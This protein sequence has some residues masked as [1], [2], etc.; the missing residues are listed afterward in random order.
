[1]RIKNLALLEEVTLEFESG[2]TAVTGETGAGKSV[3]LGA[4]GLLSGARTDKGV[5]RQ[6]QD[7]LEVEAALYFADALPIDKL[8]EAAG[9]P[10]CEDGLLLL[11]R[12][13]HQRKIPR[14]QINGSL[15]TLSQLQALGESWIDFHGPGE[16]QKLFQEKR[17]LEM[18]DTYAGNVK[19]LAA[20]ALSFEEWRKALREIETL[21]TGERLD[22]DELD[23]VRKQIKK[24]D[25]VDVSEDTIEELE[26]D[27][28]RISSAQELVSLA[29]ACSEGMIGEQSVNDLLGGVLLRLEEM[30][31]LDEGSQTLLERAQ[32]L[33]IEL[34]DLGQEL[35]HLVNDYDFDPEAIEAVTEHMNLWQELRRKYGGSVEAVLSKREELAQKIEIQ[36]DLEGVLAKKRKASVDLEAELKKQ[37]QKLTASRRKSAKLLSQKAADLLQALGFKKARLEIELIADAKLHNYGDSHCQFLFAPNAGQKLQPLNKIASSGETARVM[38][39]LKTVL[40]EADATP[41]L[42]FDE[43]DANVGGEVGRAVGAE[44]VRLAKKHQVLCVTHLPQVAS[45]AHNHYVVTKS[46]DKDSTAVD[47]ASL[48]DSR[49]DRLEELARMLG[50]RKSASARAHAEELLG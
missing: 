1:I 9:L 7:L 49:S 50:D 3:L 47:I 6:G 11:K 22:S 15:A 31:K 39:A 25:A 10:T 17:Q 40:A 35:G 34:Q 29:S 2:F 5:I 28:N 44:L 32:S 36:G 38:L 12:T 42:V 45:L 20:F 26:R 13:I 23:F 43:V 18:L 37:A 14:I 41:L 27:Y 16:P 33:Q 46:Q 8:L 4:L 48:G 30:V 19:A 24:I 21:E